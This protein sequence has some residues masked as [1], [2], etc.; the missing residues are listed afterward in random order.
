M[1]DTVLPER[2]LVAVIGELGS[3]EIADPRQGGLPLSRLEDGH[4][5]ERDVGIW[6]LLVLAS[7]AGVRLHGRDFLALAVAVAVPVAVRLATHD[8]DLSILCDD[9]IVLYRQVEFSLMTGKAAKRIYSKSKQ[10]RAS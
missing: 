2:V 9:S 3:D 10:Q 6:W 4:G 5:D 1:P 7:L 8:F